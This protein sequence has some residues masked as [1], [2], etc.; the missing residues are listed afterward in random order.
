M[1]CGGPVLAASDAL[2]PLRSQVGTR[3]RV[4][5]VAP[6]LGILGGQAVQAHA[7][8]E[9]WRDDP[10]VAAWLVPINPEPPGPLKAALQVKYLRT[11]VTEATYLP[12]L[13]RE[14]RKA[15]IVHIFSASYF[16]FLLAPLPALAVARL[17]G[18]PAL[19]NYHSGEA[20][21][22]LQRSAIARR[23]LRSADVNIVP[24]PFL[25]RVF[26]QF[27][28]PARVIPNTIDRERFG[29]RIRDPLRPRLLSTRNL[30]PLYNVGCT[31]RAFRAVQAHHAGATLTVVGA[32][33]QE[34]HLRKYAYDT[35]LRNVTFVGRVPPDQVAKFYADA[36]IYVQT[37]DIDNMPLSILEAFASG[38]PVVSTEAGGVPSMLTHGQHGLLAPLNDAGTIAAHVLRL[39]SDQPFAR[40]LVAAA[41]AS[42]EALAWPRVREQWLAAYRELLPRRAD[43][44]T[45]SV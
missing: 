22:H 23:A 10:E 9:R 3:L 12:L 44:R 4:A 7:L 21:D 1:L 42:T 31:L 45:A 36:D 40:T 29:F 28:I 41:H 13:V 32:G 5:I 14:L 20:P 25:Q 38:L 37:P 16:S 35:G 15:D 33:S 26:G 17:V 18:T 8:L 2:M 30:E 11:V 24:S 39:L 27:Q 19:M 34:Q 6:S 43:P